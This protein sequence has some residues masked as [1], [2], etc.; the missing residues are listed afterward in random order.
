MTTTNS[1]VPLRTRETKN[2]SIDE[3]QI[4]ENNRRN[5]IYKMYNKDWNNKEKIRLFRQYGPRWYR[6]VSGS[7]DDNYMAQQLRN[8][9]MLNDGINYDML[10]EY[11][12]N[13]WRMV[14]DLYGW[15]FSLDDMFPIIDIVDYNELFEIINY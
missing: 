7:Y 12:I 1:W 10:S 6:H 2:Q 11:I 14:Y 15:N 3:I 5:M 8:K 4:R 13:E 9:D